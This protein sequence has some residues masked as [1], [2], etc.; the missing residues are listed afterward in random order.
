M[1]AGLNLIKNYPAISTIQRYDNIKKEFEDYERFLVNMLKI[2][3]EKSVVN[4][5]VN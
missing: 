2:I 3:L 4:L 5:R 1:F